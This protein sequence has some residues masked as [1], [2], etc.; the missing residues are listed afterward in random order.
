MEAEVLPVNCV[1]DAGAAWRPASWAVSAR[2][3]VKGHGRNLSQ[4]K[5]GQQ[6]VIP[7]PWANPS[8]SLAAREPPREAV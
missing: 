4:H 3:P 2:V 7:C 6:Q 1:A 5:S 8:P